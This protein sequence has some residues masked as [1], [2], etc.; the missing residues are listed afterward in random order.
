MFLWGQIVPREFKRVWTLWM[1]RG[2]FLEDFGVRAWDIFLDLQVIRRT[3][4]WKKGPEAHLRRKPRGFTSNNKLFLVF[5]QLLLDGRAHRAQQ[6]S[7]LCHGLKTEQLVWKYGWD[8][9][10]LSTLWRKVWSFFL[11]SSWL[12][13]DDAF[14]S[15]CHET[16]MDSQA[17]SFLTFKSSNV[18][19][20]LMG[21]TFLHYPTKARRL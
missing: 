7:G 15:F 19:G 2:H 12:R 13:R 6:W 9:H 1:K 3:V 4:R 5:Q 11:R 8:T 17:E 20:P 21:Q 18:L 14:S 16:W 10:V